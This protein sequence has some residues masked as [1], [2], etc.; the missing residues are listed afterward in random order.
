MWTPRLCGL[1]VRRW[2]LIGHFPILYCPQRT[3]GTTAG[4]S[5][6]LCGRKLTAPLFF[7][8]P[9]QLLKTP[10]LPTVLLKIVCWVLGE[11]GLLAP[12]ESAESLVAVGSN[13]FF[14]LVFFGVTNEP[15]EE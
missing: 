9:P 13:L 6:Q 14:L 10:R 3:R 15:R 2:R 12:S 5:H 1:M 7:C 11:Y 4:V 8:T